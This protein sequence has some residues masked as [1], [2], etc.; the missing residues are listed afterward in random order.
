[1]IRSILLILFILVILLGIIWIAFPSKGNANP[2]INL[3]TPTREAES[4]ELPIFENHKEITGVT[5]LTVLRTEE[6]DRS[7]IRITKYTIQRGDTAWSI[8]QEFGLKI[9]SILWGNEG[10]NANAGGLTSGQVINILPIDGVLHTVKNGETL[11]RVA[12]IHGVRVAD[13]TGFL[14]NDLPEEPPHILFPGQ[15]IIVPGGG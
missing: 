10:M 4:V 14:G 2:Q 13:I 5:R 7:A 9:E 15:Q 11:D 8:A 12:R 3:P 1:M 6:V